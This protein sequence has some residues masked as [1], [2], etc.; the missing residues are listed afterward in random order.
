MLQCLRHRDVH[1]TANL[2]QFGQANAPVH[3]RVAVWAD[4]NKVPHRSGYVFVFRHIPRWRFRRSASDAIDFA[5]LACLFVFRSPC[6]KV[7]GKVATEDQYRSLA[8]VG[9]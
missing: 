9:G 1:L 6:L 5:G 2:L 8:I 7:G 3:D 4:R